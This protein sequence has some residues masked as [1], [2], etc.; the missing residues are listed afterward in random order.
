MQD[1]LRQRLATFVLA[2]GAAAG[3]VL[4]AA[5]ATAARSAVDGNPSVAIAT[6]PGAGDAHHAS[7]PDSTAFVLRAFAGGTAGASG[8]L[9]GARLTVLPFAD[10]VGARI[11]RYLVGFWPAERGR[12]RSTAYANPSEFI[13]VTPESRDE[14]I[15]EHFRLGDFL[16]HDQADVWPKYLVLRPGLVDKLELVIADLRSRGIRVDRLAVMSGFRTPAYNANGG[17]PRGRAQD[18]RH[19]FGDAADVYVDNGT[20]RMADLNGDGRVDWRDAQVIVRAVDRVERAHPELTGGAGV[21]AA[22]PAHGPFAHVDVR[23][24]RARWGLGA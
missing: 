10:K 24:T 19:Q 17:D 23:G 11:G 18:R 3:I 2:V 7:G 6:G 20:G 15:S 21:Y 13:R 1:K 5:P 16:T 4:R 22:T 8:K 12:L 9:R 14:Q